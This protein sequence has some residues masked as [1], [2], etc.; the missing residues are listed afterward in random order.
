MVEWLPQLR[1]Q[2]MVRS[3]IQNV[4]LGLSALACLAAC[5][6]SNP[7][8]PALGQQDGFTVKLQGRPG[9]VLVASHVQTLTT[10]TKYAHYDPILITMGNNSA[11][12]L[13]GAPAGCRT[14][15]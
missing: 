13:V 6:D 11:A 14:A 4:L 15:D 12:E 9:D 8:E 2:L 1:C 3:R 10:E 7:A 5:S